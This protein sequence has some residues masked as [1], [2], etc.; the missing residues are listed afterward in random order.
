[1]SN[2]I[3]LNNVILSYPSVFNAR[4]QSQNPKPED[5]KY[6]DATFI[7]NKDTH[8]IEI[9]AIKDEIAKLAENNNFGSTLAYKSP[10]KDGDLDPNERDEYKNSYIIKAKS[11]SRP[12]VIGKDGVTP[13]VESDDLLNTG[14]YIVLAYITLFPYTKGSKGVS[15][16]LCGLQFLSEGKLFGG[17]KFSIEGKFAPVTEEEVIASFG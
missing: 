17:Q 6:F 5:R 15:C 12:I 9:Q 2:E 3:R 11:V 7:L 1:M 8:K 10:L 14:G 16:N 4:H 13:L